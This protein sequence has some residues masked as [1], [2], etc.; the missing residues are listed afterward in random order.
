MAMGVVSAAM[1]WLGVRGQAQSLPLNPATIVGHWVFR[2]GPRAA[3]LDFKPTGYFTMSKDLEGVTQT[4]TG[5]YRVAPGTIEFN[6]GT[7][8]TERLS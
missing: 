4:S 6:P 7:A 5:T 8:S 3:R 1:L 2:D